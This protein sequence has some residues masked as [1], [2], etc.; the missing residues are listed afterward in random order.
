M[1]ALGAAAEERRWAC[2]V[3]AK[4]IG[5]PQGLAFLGDAYA[6]AESFQPK[7]KAMM[8]KTGWRVRPA[9]LLTPAE[10]KE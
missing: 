3:S 4:R 6:V 5:D 1:K 2:V 7:G 8:P 10:P 9:F